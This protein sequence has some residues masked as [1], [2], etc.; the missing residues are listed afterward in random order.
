MVNMGR[1]DDVY[2]HLQGQK[3]PASSGGGVA[4]S[5][6]VTTSPLKAR[7]PVEPAP[8][9]ATKASS[10]DPVVSAPTDLGT[11]KDPAKL[12]DQVLPS[13][14]E[15]DPVEVLLA[16]PVDQ[17]T[18]KMERHSI[19]ATSTRTGSS[20]SEARDRMK[21]ATGSGFNK[22]KFVKGLGRYVTDKNMVH[23]NHDEIRS[24]ANTVGRHARMV[25]SGA[26]LGRA[27][28]MQIK[29]DLTKQWKAGAISRESMNSFKNMLGKL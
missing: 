10:A 5:F 28:R 9:K 25:S 17:Q 8:A 3:L 19:S 15:R 6:G 29:S 12:R 13:Q 27:T 20:A 16:G 23:I 14:E 22:E 26:T 11:K 4:G 2:Q 7:P 1:L 18:S 24:F 21:F